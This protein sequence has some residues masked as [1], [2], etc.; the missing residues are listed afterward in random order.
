M[1]AVEN[2]KGSCL[3]TNSTE[4]EGYAGAQSA[5][6]PEQGE[7]EGRSRYRPG[8][9]AQDAIFRIW[10][11]AEKGYEWAVPLDLSKY[12]DTLNHEKLLNIL[13]ETVKDERAIQLIKKY[14]Y[15][16]RRVPNGTHGAVRGREF[17][18]PSYSIAGII[19]DK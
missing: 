5:V 11:Y 18:T 6:Q 8:R 15:W 10:G 14:L 2:A 1:E 17:V 7:T 19:R 3:Q 16:T 4:C 13:R 12:F 9:S